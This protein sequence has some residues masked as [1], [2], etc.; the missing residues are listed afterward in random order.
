[1]RQQFST[2]AAVVVAL[3]PPYPFTSN[4]RSVEGQTISSGIGIRYYH[5]VK[6]GEEKMGW[7]KVGKVLIT[8]IM[9]MIMMIRMMVVK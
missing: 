6:G 4:I 1:M 2:T 7:E 9:M 3:N 5:V 8:I